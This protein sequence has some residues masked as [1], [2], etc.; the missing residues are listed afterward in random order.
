[1]TDKLDLQD[2]AHLARVAEG[3]G[4]RVPEAAVARLMLAGVV[5]RPEHVCDGGPSLEL[6]PAGLAL[7]RSS[8][9]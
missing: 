3:Q 2:L 6:T 9:Q 1:M 5:R 4:A 8:D 7:V